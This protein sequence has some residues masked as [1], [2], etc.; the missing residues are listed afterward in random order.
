[1]SIAVPAIAENGL[2]FVVFGAVAFSVVM[3][4]LF[5]VTRGSE[6]LYDHIGRG[7]ITREGEQGSSASA[8]A[9]DS[10]QARAEREQEVRQM[11]GARSERLVRQGQ[12]ALDIDAETARLLDPKPDAASPSPAL[13]D[14]VRQLVV[15]RNERRQR[16]GLEPLDVDAEVARTMEELGP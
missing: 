1:V 10:A 16:Q 11:L 2:S 12:P 4:L 5:F 15:A 13:L 6:S 7:G 9:P 3:S 14:E 8:P